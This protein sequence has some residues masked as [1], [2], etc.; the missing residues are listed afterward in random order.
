MIR[1]EHCGGVGALYQHDVFDTVKCHDS[2]ATV[3]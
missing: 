3:I 2:L 1:A